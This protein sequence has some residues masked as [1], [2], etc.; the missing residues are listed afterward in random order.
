MYTLHLTVIPVMDLYHV[1]GSIW[2]SHQDGTGE[3]VAT[4]AHDFQLSDAWLEE[5][6]STTLVEVVRQ[7]AE[8]TMRA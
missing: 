1:S 8:M 7:W 6:G 2:E 3:L 4:F 5:D